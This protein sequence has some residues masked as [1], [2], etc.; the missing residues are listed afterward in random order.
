M[1]AFGLALCPE[2]G[3]GH[4]THTCCSKNRTFCTH[5]QWRCKNFALAPMSHLVKL[6]LPNIYRPQQSCEG[7]VFTPLC[8]S[9]GG[10]VLPQC[11]LGYYHPSPRDRPPL[12]SRHPP[13]PEGAPP[14]SRHP[15]ADG[16]CCGR[17]ASYL[18]AFLLYLCELRKF[19]FLVASR[20]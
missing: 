11:M 14:R 20:I 18:N 7:Y 3:W 16:Y 4:S 5:R 17:Y 13:P 6:S 1:V 10:G 19:P 2:M 15:P 8:L 9:M 12:W